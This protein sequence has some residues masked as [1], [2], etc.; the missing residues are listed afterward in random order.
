[1][2]TNILENAR[3]ALK[4]FNHEIL[5]AEFDQGLK[6]QDN[7]FDCILCADVIEHMIDVRS[8]FRE[9]FRLLKID[10]KLI[11]STP[12]IAKAKN[13]LTLLLGRFPSTSANNEGFGTRENESLLD[14][15]HFHYFTFRLLNLLAKESGFNKIKNY[16]FGRFG[17]LHNF[18]PRLL[19]GASAIVCTK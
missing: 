9:F 5:I 7:F 10:G 18:Y 3:K 1:M 14:G 11:L 12:N 8:A 19:S 16:G 6:Y 17:K 2:A 15:G 13:R 4:G